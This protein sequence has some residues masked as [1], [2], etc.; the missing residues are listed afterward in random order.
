MGVIEHHV[1]GCSGWCGGV[2]FELFL[3]QCQGKG[4]LM[5]LFLVGSISRSQDTHF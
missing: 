2:E 5:Y 1:L 3:F 4:S